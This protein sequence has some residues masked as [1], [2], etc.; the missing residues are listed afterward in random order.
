[1]NVMEFVTDQ[2]PALSNVPVVTLGGGVVVVAFWTLY[3]FSKSVEC[4][5]IAGTAA[6]YA[7]VPLLIAWT[8]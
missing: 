2:F 4:L 1:M 7:L 6:S 5:V 3:R 8:H